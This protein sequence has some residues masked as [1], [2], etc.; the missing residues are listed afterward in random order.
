MDKEC[1]YKTYQS[2]LENNP[3]ACYVIDLHGNFLLINDAAVDLIG[4][5]RADLLYKPFASILDESYIEAT[6]LTLLRIMN[7]HSKSERFNTVIRTTEG[8]LKQLSVTAVPIF[9]EN[10][11]C[12]V[13][14]IAKNITEINQ[15]QTLLNGQNKVLEML[16]KGFPLSSIL[17][18][19]IYLI[20]KSSNGGTCSISLTEENSD[21]LILYSSPNLPIEYSDK[22]RCIP[23]SPSTGS[24]GTAAFLKETVIVS[25]IET[26]PLWTDFKDLALEHNLKACWS[27][28]FFDQAQNVLGVFA[29]YYNKPSEPAESD[30][31]LI[32][33]AT[34]LTSLVIQHFYAEEKI[35]YMAYHDALTGLPNRRLFDDRVNSAIQN[36]L[37][38]RHTLGLLYIDL[39]RF[40]IINDSLGHNIGDLLLKEVSKQLLGCIRSNDTFSRQGGDEFTIL[41]H[42]VSK[43]DVSSIA[44]RIIDILSKPF[45]IEGNEIFVTPSIGISLYPHDGQ[46]KDELLRKADLAMYQAKRSGRNNFQF[47][48]K[49]LD[50]IVQERLELENHLRKALDKEE[51]TLHYQPIIDLSTNKMS[52]VEALIRW[53]H[54][55][56]GMVPP[57]KFIPIAEETGLIVPIGEWVIRTACLQIKEWETN[58]FGQ[59]SVSINLSIRQFYQSN[60][61]NMM[62]SILNKTAINPRLLIVEIT[63]S[64]TMDVESATQILHELKNLGLTIAMDDFGTGYSSFSYLKT[65]PIDFLKIDQSFIRDIAINLSDENIATAILLM[66]HNLGLKVIAEGVELAEQLEVL[67]QH[68]CHKAQGYYFSKPLPVYELEQYLNN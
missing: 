29:M 13:G 56:F 68:D 37:T 51:F 43:S 62:Q 28:P 8:V 9:N 48:D 17:N 66:A 25:D 38:N 65:F 35:N 32:E 16:A 53:E 7:G 63:E 14:G 58:G 50:K 59:I 11:I 42:N 19:I 64:M 6:N 46:N 26:N 3:D 20:E 47:Y 41:L 45:I 52:G 67:K 60:L 22:L 27:S 30:R 61:I 1:L 10:E 57:N 55:T 40:K 49:Q 4:I 36:G 2:L 44:N 12:G 24:C 15:I 31:I 39:D 54:P 5:K 34:Y 33:K 23:I 21:T 18:E